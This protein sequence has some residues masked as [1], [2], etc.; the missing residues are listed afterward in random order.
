MIQ[1]VLVVAGECGL[2]I[3][4][5]HSNVLLFNH[6]GISL[7]EVG[8]NKS[9]KY[10][11]TDV[12]DCRICCREYKHGKI[13]SEEKIANLT[14]AIARLSNKLVRGKNTGRVASV[15]QL[16]VLGATAAVVWAK[17]EKIHLLRV[18][19]K[20]LEA[21]SKCTSLHASGSIAGGNGAIYSFHTN[22]E[23]K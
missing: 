9:I 13:E 15:V 2:N 3:N 18:E 10:L 19:N 23:R 21:D 12:E 5:G 7:E 16:L 4:K 22:S 1:M 6:Y 11:V 17:E 8:G 20:V 14:S